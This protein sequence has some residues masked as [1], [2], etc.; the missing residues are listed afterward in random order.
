MRFIQILSLVFLSACVPA[1]IAGVAGTGTIVAQERTTGQAVDDTG[2]YWKIKNLYLQQNAQDLLAGVG[3]NV[4]QGRVYLTGNVNTPEARID[5]VKLAWQPNGVTEVN[6]EIN[7]NS[8]KTIKEIFSSRALKAEIAA[9]L[10]TEK[11]VRSVNYSIEV[12]EGVVYLMGIA[13]DTEELDTVTSIASTT[14][15]VQ[16]VV[17]HVILKDAINRG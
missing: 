3:V 10:I 12:V 15:G 6:N 5:A 11:N 8:E 1:V 13:Q 2:I 17:S 9:K 16:K 14:K 7:I 4:I